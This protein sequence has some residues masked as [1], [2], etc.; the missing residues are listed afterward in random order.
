LVGEADDTLATVTRSRLRRGAAN[1]RG[2][3]HRTSAA[4][5]LAPNAALCRGRR[6]TT[7]R[8]LAS[9]TG[10]AARR[11]RIYG[12]ATSPAHTELPARLTSSAK[13]SDE[14]SQLA[15][16]NSQ[17]RQT[18]RLKLMVYAFEHARL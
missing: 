8:I 7:C 12:R 9:S 6:M 13:A 15:N 11:R 18:S 3:E 16:G 1:A 2:F 14:R 10:P 17:E 5:A 4:T